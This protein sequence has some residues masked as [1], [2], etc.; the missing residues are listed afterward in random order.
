MQVYAITRAEILPLH[1][2][3]A[4]LVSK[5]LRCIEVRADLAR[6]APEIILRVPQLHNRSLS[7]ARTKNSS[8]GNAGFAFHS[9]SPLAATWLIHLQHRQYKYARACMFD[10]ENT[11][12]R[13]YTNAKQTQKCN[14]KHAR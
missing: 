5:Q 11:R 8:T 10:D 14:C 9:S 3:S 13:K 6:Q 1:C 7:L 4:G 12:V 2:G